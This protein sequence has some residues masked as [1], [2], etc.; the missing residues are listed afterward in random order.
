MPAN[1]NWMRGSTPVQHSHFEWCVDAAGALHL[2]SGRGHFHITAGELVRLRKYLLKQPRRL[3]NNK[4][5][6]PATITPGDAIG[7]DFIVATLGRQGSQIWA[8]HLVGVL[9]QAGLLKQ[10]RGPRGYRAYQAIAGR[11][12]QTALTGNAARP[13]ISPQAGRP[14][15]TP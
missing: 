4:D 1:C 2:R 13:A 5:G 8:S 14:F 12:W 6:R 7:W 3:G 9:F 15:A 11:C 10:F